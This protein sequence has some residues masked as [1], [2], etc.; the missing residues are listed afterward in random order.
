MRT[1]AKLLA[2]QLV[3]AALVLAPLAA[4]AADADVKVT[5]SAMSDKALIGRNDQN[6]GKITPTQTKRHVVT[7]TNLGPSTALGIE[8]AKPTI[9]THFTQKPTVPPVNGVNPPFKG[10]YGLSNV[11]GCVLKSFTCTGIY[12]ETGSTETS[13]KCTK[14]GELAID[15]NDDR[16][17][18]CTIGSIS[19]VA[20][21]N[22]ATVDLD[23]TWPGTIDDPNTDAREDIPAACPDTI[24]LTPTTVVVTTTGTTDPDATNNTASNTPT[25]AP[26][27][28]L[29]LKLAADRGEASPG[30]QVNVTGSVENLGPCTAADVFVVDWDGTSDLKRKWVEGSTF[31]CTDNPDWGPAQADWADTNGNGCW[32]QDIAVGQTKQFGASY[33]IGP[34]ASDELQR[35]TTINAQSYSGFFPYY[36][37]ANGADAGA[38]LDPDETD[39][40]KA[41]NI[42]SK[43][44][45]SSCATGGIPGVLGLLLVAMPLIRR[46]RSR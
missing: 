12:G 10:K 18:P 46:R 43:Q 29:T 37:P 8:I 39:N 1:N 2:K 15:P 30:E 6:P 24:T 11:T 31:G 42:I 20:G 41:V 25:S 26:Q 34:L 17:W 16:S 45:V 35:S 23:I 32:L 9:D 36:Y 38:T 13:Q 22:V 5:I 14:A 7:L 27:A 21:K 28:F 40:G 19:D 4:R 33:I 3:L 44:S